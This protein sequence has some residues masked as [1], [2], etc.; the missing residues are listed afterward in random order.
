MPKNNF[1][2]DRRGERGNV[3][4]I[5]FMAIVLIAALTAAI[6]GSNRSETSGIDSENLIIRITEVQRYASELERAV[7]FIMQNGLSEEDIRFSHPENHADYGDLGADGDP[8]DQVFHRTGGG[9]NYREAP[10]S[11]NDGSPWEFYGSTHLP[12]VG[13]NRADLVAVL[14]NV[15]QGFCDKINEVNGQNGTPSD[16]GGGAATAGNAGDCVHAG[17]AA[18]FDAGQQFYATANTVDE[19]TFEQDPTVAQVRTA[20]QACVVC[21]LDGENHFYHV[22]LAR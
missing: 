1:Y 18:R 4:I 12:G 14:P 5:V 21:A 13:S 15:T 6:Q 8:T 9:A 11:I 20:P 19:A 22:L 7:L 10:D 16:T 17:V 2:D 3:L